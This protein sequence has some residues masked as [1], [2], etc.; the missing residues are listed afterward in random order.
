LQEVQEKVGVKQFIEAFVTFESIKNCG[1]TYKEVISTCT[2]TLIDR[3]QFIQDNGGVLGGDGGEAA[4]HELEDEDDFFD[5]EEFEEQ[6]VQQAVERS[7]ETLQEDAVTREA[8]ARS[9]T[10]TA[11]GNHELF[12]FGGAH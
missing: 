2:D 12:Q 7:A 9:E 10:D 1:Y 4:A 3:H 11:G 8:I 6:L 5:A